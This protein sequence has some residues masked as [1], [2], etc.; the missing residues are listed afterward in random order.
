VSEIDRYL[1]ELRAR[2]PLGV[3]ARVVA[4]VEEHLRESGR[5]V[6]EEEA[7]ARFGSAQALADSYRGRVRWVYAAGALLAALAFPVLSYPIP[8]NLLPP[9]PWPSA[10][11][12]PAELAWKRDWIIALFLFAVVAGAVALGGF[13]RNRRLIVWPAALS[14]GAI[15]AAGVLG[16]LLSWQWREHVVGT[17]DTLL[18]LGP[19]QVALALAGLALLARAAALSRA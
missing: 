3:R 17:P 11:E 13:L 2:L 5:A 9:A 10:D 1:S 6:G 18:V 4:E 16:T 12:M 14:L 15:A 19:V 7:I 8:E